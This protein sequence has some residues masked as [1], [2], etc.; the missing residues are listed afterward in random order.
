[1]A[2][3]PKAAGESGGRAPLLAGMDV[4][5]FTYLQ[6]DELNGLLNLLRDSTAVHLYLILR[7]TCVFKTGEFLGSY[8]RLRDLMTPP[9]PERGLRRPG[10]SY[11]QC[12]SAVDA[13]IAVGLVK[14]AKK[15]EELG[16][17]RLRV[18]PMHARSQANTAPSANVRPAD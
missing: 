1:M 10:P 16:Q 14:R 2:T 12:R 11:K 3:R 7:T 9:Q 15:N 5:D 18:V 13:L 4:P 8:A 6:A 17:L